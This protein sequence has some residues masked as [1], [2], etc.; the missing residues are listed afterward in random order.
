[1]RKQSVGT[2]LIC[3]AW[4]LSACVQTAPQASAP[5]ASA[6]PVV[7]S[8]GVELPADAAPLD[9]Q[10]LR[11][12][13]FEGKHFD[14]MRNEYEGF[15]Y[16]NTIETLARMDADGVW[17]PGAADSW[18]VSEDGRT[19]TF[20]L[21]QDAKWSDGTPI[22]A[23]DWVYSFH[24]YVDPAMANVYAWFLF[25]IE[26]AEAV[27][28]GEMPVEEMGVQQIDDHTFSVT[29]KVSLPY[30]MYTLNWHAVPVPMHMVEEHG[31]AWADS[32]ETAPSNGPFMIKEWNRGQNVIFTLNPYYNGPWKPKLE[33]QT[34]VIVPQGYD[35]YLQMYQAGDIDVTSGLRGDQLAQVLADPELSTQAYVSTD[36]RT[37]Y[38][39]MN[40]GQPPFD[41]LE[42]RQAFMHAVDR[43]ALCNEVMRGTCIP[44]YG[45]LPTDFPC[46]Q[47]DN[48]ALQEHQKF[49][50]D[51]AKQLMEAAGYPGGAGFP[52]LTL[53]TR[54]GEFAREAEA[55][56]RML[57]DNLGITVN[58]QD[59]ERATFVDL[60]TKGELIFAFTRWGADFI[61]PSNF[62]DWWDDADFNKFV[63]ADFTSLIDEARPM[64]DA[65]QRCEVYHQAEEILVSEGPAVFM[66][67]PKVATLYKPYV[68]DIPLSKTGTLGNRNDF[69]ANSIYIAQ[70]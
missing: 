70:H 5:E 34:M 37:A 32:P 21:R 65:A 8:L 44:G 46:T 19:W 9:Q 53:Y 15:A 55:V 52:E 56:Q 14:T 25:D 27:N 68:K 1:M 24:R 11:Y 41:K 48:A 63:N 43:E 23:A 51:M 39:Y 58:V 6:G 61:D 2:L 3:L 50:P 62:F 69:I 33:Q 45:L 64:T 57:S 4:L 38:L 36:P 29:T 12:A 40:M 26:N 49:D 35:Q 18:E 67:Y 66:L 60:R 16:E 31:D 42:V 47:N 10:V 22:T 13:G 20:H 28:K 7:N 30:Y 59:M 17:H 54:E